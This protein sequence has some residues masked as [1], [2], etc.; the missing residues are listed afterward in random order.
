MVEIFSFFLSFWV[1]ALSF[2]LHPSFFLSPLLSFFRLNPFIQENACAEIHKIPSNSSLLPWSPLIWFSLNFS[3]FPS[4]TMPSQRTIT[5]TSQLKKR[6][7]LWKHNFLI[8][9]IE[10]HVLL[11]RIQD[12]L[13]KKT[14][15]LM[16]I[17]VPTANSY[18]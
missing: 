10:E 9:L 8:L 2:P 17:I 14:P 5:T 7:M 16:L 12:N 4:W 6:C 1:F 11:N 13:K 18:N 15:K 3:I